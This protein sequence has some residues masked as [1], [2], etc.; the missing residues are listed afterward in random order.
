MHI[1]VIAKMGIEIQRVFGRS[2]PLL[3]RDRANSEHNRKSHPNVVSA[4]TSP[5]LWLIK[6]M[7]VISLTL[8]GVIPPAIAERLPR[9]DLFDEEELD[10]FE[11]TEQ[12]L[13]ISVIETWPEARMPRS[14]SSM[15]L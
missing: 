10:R 4:Q 8:I 1:V 5:L 3:G 15:V 6:V 2:R 9:E 13:Q 7:I 12:L 11:L 14:V